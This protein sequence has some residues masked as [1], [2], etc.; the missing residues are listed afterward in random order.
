MYVLM[1]NRFPDN[2]IETYR[3]NSKTAP[4]ILALIENIHM[5]F[6][7][8]NNEDSYELKLCSAYSGFVLYCN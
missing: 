6:K 4:H 1:E 8:I 7:G 2:T 3:M 5:Q